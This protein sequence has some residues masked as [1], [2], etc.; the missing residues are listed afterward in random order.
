MLGAMSLQG[1][2]RRRLRTN[3]IALVAAIAV[4]AIALA[5]A[6]RSDA[7]TVAANGF[8]SQR[9]G[10]SFPNYGNAKDPVDLTTDDVVRLFGRGVCVNAKGACVLTP[11]AEAWMEAEN[12][13]MSDGHCYGMATSSQLFFQDRR[14]LPAPA[15]GA[16]TTPELAF[17]TPKLQSW[18][19]YLWTLQDMPAV[20]ATKVD[21]TPAKVVKTLETEFAAGGSEYVIAIYGKQGGHAITPLAIEDDGGGKRRI[22]VYDN[23]WPG[24]TRYIHVDTDA[25]KWSYQLAPGM[26]WKGSAKTKTLTLEDPSVALG[27]QPCYICARDGGAGVGKRLTLQ[28]TGDDARGEHGPLTVTDQRGRRAGF[29]GSRT[30]NDIRGARVR[31]PLTSPL[32]DAPPA[33]VELPSRNSYRVVLERGGG[34]SRLSEDVHLIGRGFSVGAEKVEIRRGETDALEITRNARTV[35]FVNDERGVESPSVVVSASNPKGGFAYRLEVSPAGVDPNAGISVRFNS[36][37][38]AVRISNDGGSRVE[39]VDL[40]LAQYSKKGTGGGEISLKIKRDKAKTL[41]LSDLRP[42]K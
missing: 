33:T 12:Y 4:C 38:E 24:E 17:D 21:S 15:F 40:D 13:A 5:L 29:R 32:R 30:F 31:R 39:R 10:Y 25:Q 26:T 14:G 16:P 36:R 37:T 18:I 23:N 28:L 6:P 8:T 19:A 20:A 35:S 42:S 3:A 34:K 11:E 41:K 27:H 1:E 2:T 22:A 9:D 7:A